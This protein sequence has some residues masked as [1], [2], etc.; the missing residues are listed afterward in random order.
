MLKMQNEP[1]RSDRP[2]DVTITTCTLVSTTQ[3]SLA[4]CA[5][6]WVL[7]LLKIYLRHRRCTFAM[8]RSVRILRARKVARKRRDMSPDYLQVALQ[9]ALAKVRGMCS[10]HWRKK[11]CQRG[12]PSVYIVIQLGY[13]YD[14]AAAAKEAADVLTRELEI[15]VVDLTIIVTY[16]DTAFWTLASG[17]MIAS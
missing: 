5:C 8:V 14:N 2:G 4:Y 9:S 3:A 16:T 17:E 6:H 7:R 15:I 12:Y 10:Y 11:F 13:L 1:L